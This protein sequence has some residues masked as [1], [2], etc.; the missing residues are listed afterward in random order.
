M[1]VFLQW[2]ET[3]HGTEC[4]FKE[5]VHISSGYLNAKEAIKF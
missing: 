4:I 1:Q 3:W 5:I 2:K